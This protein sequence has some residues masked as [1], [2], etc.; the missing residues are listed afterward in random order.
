[1]KQDLSGASF[2]Q[3]VHS[4]LGRNKTSLGENDPRRGYTKIYSSFFSGSSEHVGK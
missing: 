2:V 3:K 1:M 4:A